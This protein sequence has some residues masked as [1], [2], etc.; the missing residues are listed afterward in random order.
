MKKI[1]TKMIFFFAEKLKHFGKVR[2]NFKS[3]FVPYYRFLCRALWK[4]GY[5]YIYH[6]EL[7]I[8]QKC[9]LKCGKCSFFMPYF[10]EPVDYALNDL[11]R[12]MDKLFECIDAIQIFRILGGEPFLYKDLEPII[13]KALSSPKVKTVD[14]VTN[15]TI[16][17]SE[18]LLSAM[19][20]PKLS[21]QIS[22]YGKC[23]RNKMALKAI[24]DKAGVKCVIRG[25]KEKVWFDAG[26]LENRGRD[27]SEI[28]K[29]MKR[30]GNICRSFHN[31][32]L[33][34]CPRASFGTKLGIPDYEK[35]F[36][37][38]RLRYD[39][40]VLRRKIYELNQKQYLV[41]CNYCDEGTDKFIAIPVAEQLDD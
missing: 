25:A 40:N 1:I 15:G 2:V 33:Y 8:T 24:C 14:I 35:D 17:P 12:Y 13:N 16:I 9:T 36:V 38:F 11:L 22:D 5:L 32:K 23:S 21:V 26:G 41:A 3:F 31:G 19:K 30:C 7:P 39:R 27:V 10:K 18:K 28:K 20:N 34:F 29:Q 6:I 37:D 4:Y